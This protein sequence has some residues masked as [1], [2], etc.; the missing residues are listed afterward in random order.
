[1][2]AFG[3]PQHWASEIGEARSHHSADPARLRKA[4]VKLQK[5]YAADAEAICEAAQRPTMRFVV[6]K[7]EEVQAAAFVFRARDL[8]V[9]QRPQITNAL[10]RHL[11]EFSIVVANGPTHV[12]H[13]GQVA[14]ELAEP[15]AEIARPILQML[16]DPLHRLDT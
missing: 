15:L 12:P 1:M 5:N 3:S 6:P 4:Y 10:R 11:A 8:L 9:K 16:V 13:Q 7:S 2:E 14:D